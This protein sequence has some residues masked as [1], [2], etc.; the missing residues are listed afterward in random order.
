MEGTEVEPN[1]TIM[2]L[3]KDG[4]K[5][6]QLKGIVYYLQNHFMACIFC[7]GDMVWFHDRLEPNLKYEGLL[8]TLPDLHVRKLNSASAAIYFLLD[9]PQ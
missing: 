8:T 7:C 4:N 2:I 3:M 1:P 6:Y 5:D 9:T